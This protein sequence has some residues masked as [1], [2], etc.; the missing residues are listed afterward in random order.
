V[1]SVWARERD[2]Q[3][4]YRK[5]LRRKLS[6]YEKNVP[7]HVQAAR[8]LQQQG[9]SLRRGDWVEYLITV[10]GPEP[11]ASGTMVQSPIDYN[12]YV[13]RQ[14]APVAD[15]ILHSLGLSFAELTKPQLNLF[16]RALFKSQSAEKKRS[17]MTTHML[18]G[19]PDMSLIEAIYQ[20]RSVRGFLDREIPDATLQ[21]ILEIAQRAP[22]NCNVQP[23]KVFIAKGALNKRISQQMQD[24]VKEGVPGNPDYPYRGTFRGEYR[25]K[26][27][28]CAVALYSEMGIARDDKAGRMRALLRNYEF[29]DAPYMAFIGMD[30]EFGTTVALD[31]GMYAQNLMLALRAF[32]LD[33]CPMGAMRQYPDLVREAFGLGEETRILFGIAFGYEDPSVPANRTRVDRDAVEANVIIK[34]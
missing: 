34:S 19:D 3:L 8:K 2:E 10:N 29:F 6:D 27:V 28:D 33:S 4:V 7:P 13:E 26:Q 21:R 17:A 9:V 22:S 11:L 15:G 32:G 25:R 30:Q 12:H 23:W 5:R 31:V 14:L 16:C 18:P 20:R 24:L 1:A